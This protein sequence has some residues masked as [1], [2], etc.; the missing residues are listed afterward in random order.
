M[1]LRPLFTGID[2]VAPLLAAGVA[3][4]TPNRRLSRAI[5]QAEPLYR[6][7]QGT[8]VWPSSTVLPLRQYWI[9]RWQRA[10]TRGL[11]P[12]RTLIDAKRQQLIWRRVIDADEAL[13]F[14][15]LS[16]TRAATLSQEASERLALWRVDPNDSQTR[17]SFSFD[18]DCK[19]FLRWESHFRKALEDLDCITPEQALEQ[20]LNCPEALDQAV[21]LLTEDELPPLHRALCDAAPSCQQL[22]PPVQQARLMPVRV[23][24]DPRAELQCAAR[25]CR[26]QVERD[27]QGRYAVVLSDMQGDR[28]RME[29]Y[30][31]QEF[32]CLTQNYASLPV[33]FATGFMLDRV[34]L[35]SDALRILQCSLNEV[36]V[37]N[38]VAVLQS[39]FIAPM[40]FRKDHS[41]RCVRALR[42]LARERIPQRVMRSV[43]D[44]LLDEELGSP[45]WDK[46]F[47]L[48]TNGRWLR[49]ERLPSQWLAPFKAILTAWGWPRGA[50][51]DSLEYQ[52]A[53]QWQEAMDEFASL[54]AFTGVLPLGEAIQCLKDLMAE[55]QFQPRTNDQAIQVLGPL[56][57]TGLSFDAIW[58]CGMTAARWPAAAKPNPYLPHSLQ[59]EQRM[60]HADP[61]WERRWAMA[62]WEQWQSGAGQVYCSYVNQLDGA[63]ALPSPLI[64]TIPRQPDVENWQVDPRWREQAARGEV[65][66]VTLN[67][68]PIA[69]DERAFAGVGAGALE[70]QSNCP[71]QAFAASRL[72]ATQAPTLAAGLLASERGILLH[73]ALFAIWGS[74]ENSDRLALTSAGQLHEIIDS[75]LD[76]AS[77]G[78]SKERVD[79]LGGDILMLE[80]Q[81]L[82]TVLMR[83][84]ELER[85]RPESFVVLGRE[86]PRE[87]VLGKLKLRLRLD[88][89]DQLSDGRQLIIDYKSGAIGSVNQWLGDRPTRPQLPLYALL[90][91]P[92]AAISYAS[93]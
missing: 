93:L 47:Q 3:V 46:V 85:E 2:R 54:D 69:G 78:L 10:V 38:I 28:D 82:A 52:Q 44:T 33:N 45:P 79:V 22:I 67:A 36:A 30:L 13:P 34:T 11:L 12:P 48:A 86:E 80:R 68:V 56:E 27:P 77:Q 42:E 21:A 92:A 64:K 35:V 7:A 50:A 6:R 25:W 59:R 51:L 18:E 66:L 8:D 81:R 73:R 17:Q 9:E 60:P 89:I 70:Q 37:E 55:Q 20:L 26:E 61:S 24:A 88:R 5:L 76:Y 40:A 14:S 75:G 72:N 29:H 63:E 71:F 4:L 90:S 62:R 15:L 43:L 41:E 83:W 32:A 31:R 91:P 65:E 58:I 23:F 74:L 53:V 19:A 57:T 49:R 87:H 16:P 39:R 84:L 1:S